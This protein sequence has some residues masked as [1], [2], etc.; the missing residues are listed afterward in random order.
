MSWKAIDIKTGKPLAVAEY[1]S[2][3]NQLLLKRVARGDFKNVPY[4][5][6]YPHPVMFIENRLTATEAASIRFAQSRKMKVG[7]AGD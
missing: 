7:E 5:Q 6:T 2:E 1:K 3:A 4:G